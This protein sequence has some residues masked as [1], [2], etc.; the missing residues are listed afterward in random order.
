MKRGWG[1]LFLTFIQVKSVIP[2]GII[3]FCILCDQ[4]LSIYGLYPQNAVMCLPSHEWKG[5][6]SIIIRLSVEEELFPFSIQKTSLL[7]LNMCMYLSV[8]ATATYVKPVCIGDYVI[9]S[10]ILEISK[11]EKVTIS[12]FL[13]E[14][15]K[16]SD[17]CNKETTARITL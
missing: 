17:I 15:T 11:Q 12:I 9:Y 16:Q 1:N 2:A 7:P 6:V 8:S 13:L 3:Q 5:A 14:K 10:Y 4:S